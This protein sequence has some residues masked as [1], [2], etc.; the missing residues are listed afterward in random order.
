M[1]GGGSGSPGRTAGQNILAGVPIR[2]FAKRVPDKKMKTELQLIDPSGDVIQTFST[3]PDRE[4]KEK[5]LNVEAGVNELRW[6]MRYP[7]AETF[8]GMVLWGGGTRGPL[9]VPGVYQAKLTVSKSSTDNGTLTSEENTIFNQTIDFKIEKDPR[10]SATLADFQSQFNFLIGVRDK[11]SEIHLA[12]KNTRDIREQLKS[13]QSRLE[14][15][16]GNE[17]LVEKAKNLDQELVNVEQ[18]L[19]QTKNESPQDPLNYPIRLNNRLSGL[20]GVASAGDHRPTRQSIAVRNQLIQEID[21]LLTTQKTVVDQGIREFN[22]AVRKA[23]VPAIFTK[24]P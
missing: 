18:A 16:D 4:R 1:R 19:Y 22:E 13:L 20:V 12:I 8:E 6:D 14:K 17:D 2:F 15:G 24:V 3:Q 9:A 5:K 7:G 21:D 10:S 11:L 23:S